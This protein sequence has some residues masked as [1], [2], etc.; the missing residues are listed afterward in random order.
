MAEI[1]YETITITFSKLVKTGVAIQFGDIATKEDIAQ[2]EALID[3]LY[4]DD[5]SRVVEITSSE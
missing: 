4:Q 3:E 5:E 2:I 1:A